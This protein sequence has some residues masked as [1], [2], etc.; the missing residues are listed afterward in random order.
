M[1]APPCVG[2]CDAKIDRRDKP[3]TRVVRGIT[4]QG[5]KRFTDCVTCTDDGVHQGRPDADALEVRHHSN[6]PQ[7]DTRHGTDVATTA[8]DVSR[9]PMVDLGYPREN[10]QPTVTRP[11]L[12]KQACL[13]WFAVAL[14]EG[15]GHYGSRGGMVWRTFTS[16]NHGM[17]LLV[18]ASNIGLIGLRG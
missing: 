11:Q 13:D 14:I 6:G 17:T 3:K 4:Q 2:G 10:R 18:A 5:D 9:H 7:A 15:C 1:G 8:D 12:I 16:D